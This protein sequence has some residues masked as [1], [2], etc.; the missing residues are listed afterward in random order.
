LKPTNAASISTGPGV[1]CPS[2][3]TVN[4]LLRCQPAELGD[5]LIL[6]EGQHRETA[7]EGER[8]NP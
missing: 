7:S 2:A 6:D 5:D 8:A 3:E 4:E 1:N